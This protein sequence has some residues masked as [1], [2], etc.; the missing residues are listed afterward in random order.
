MHANITTLFPANLIPLCLTQ[1]KH[2]KVV[3]VWL[4]HPQLPLDPLNQL[5]LLIELAS[6]FGGLKESGGGTGAGQ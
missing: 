5:A 3:W 1:F 2:I 4:A 6:L